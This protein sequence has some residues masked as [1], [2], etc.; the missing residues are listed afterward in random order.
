MDRYINRYI[1]RFYRNEC[2]V[3]ETYA[4]NL[5]TNAGVEKRYLS[6][7]MDVHSGRITGWH[8]ACE[9]GKD[10]ELEALRIA[11]QISGLPEKVLTER[12][13]LDG[14]VRNSRSHMLSHAFK[15]MDHFNELLINFLREAIT[16]MPDNMYGLRIDEFAGYVSLFVGKYNAGKEI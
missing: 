15:M 12:R 7:F 4:F 6:V 5:I 8:V 11:I 13:R 16:G 9:T 2:W 14:M 3:G 1:N 10:T